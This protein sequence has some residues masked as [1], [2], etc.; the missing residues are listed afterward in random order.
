VAVQ[1]TTAGVTLTLPAAR[2]AFD[3]VIALDLAAR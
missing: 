2:D 1:Q 3:T